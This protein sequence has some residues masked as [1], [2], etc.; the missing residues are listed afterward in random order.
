VLPMH[1]F[2]PGPGQPD[3]CT[4][5][6]AAVFRERHGPP[7]RRTDGAGINWNRADRKAFHGGS[8]LAVAGYSLPPGFHWDVSQRGRSIRLTNSS[9]VWRLKGNRAY[10]NVYPDSHI[11]PPKTPGVR[12]VWPKS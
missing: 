5:E 10:V 8:S 9:Q 7:A 6:G 4:E 3:L 11:R 2:S 1:V 12:R